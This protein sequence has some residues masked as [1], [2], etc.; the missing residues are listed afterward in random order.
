MTDRERELVSDGFTAQNMLIRE[1]LARAAPELDYDTVT[2]GVLR[3]VLSRGFMAWLI[4]HP[5][6]ELVSR[7]QEEQAVTRKHLPKQLRLLD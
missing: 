3:D 5:D 6:R 4:T 2:L 7:F 1:Y